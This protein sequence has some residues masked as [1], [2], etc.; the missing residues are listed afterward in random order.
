MINCQSGLKY[1]ENSSKSSLSFNFHITACAPVRSTNIL[2]TSMTSHIVANTSESTL[3]VIRMVIYIINYQSGL[4]YG[5][6]S[7]KSAL[8]SNFQ[9]AAS[10]PARSTNILKT[11]MTSHIVANTS[12]STLHVIRMA[13]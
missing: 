12:E 11:S 9:V 7:S 6:N 1:D 8:S 5:E 10:V 2:K 4:K 13:I 3:H